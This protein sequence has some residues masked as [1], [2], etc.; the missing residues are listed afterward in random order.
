[1]S[2]RAILF[3]IVAFSL[4]LQQ[5]CYSQ[6]RF[7]TYLGVGLGGHFEKQF[8]YSTQKSNGRLSIAITQYAKL[9]EKFSIGLSAMASGRMSALLGGAPPWDY[10][11]PASNTVLINYNN[12]NAATY[13]IKAKY[14]WFSKAG[15]LIYSDLGIGISK[16]TYLHASRSTLS[17]APELG[18][19]FYA[20]QLAAIFIWGGQTPSF[21]A[22]SSLPNSTVLTSIQ[23]NRMYLTISYRLFDF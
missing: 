23:S 10:Y 20:F 15:I 12:L 13:L 14:N 5:N 2:S 9:A 1:M 22:N 6:K 18:V 11:D 8:P 19:N 3:C 7:S 17:I 16:Y 4:S 21:T